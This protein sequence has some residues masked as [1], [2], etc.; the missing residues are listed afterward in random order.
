MLLH[1]LP[2]Q[3]TE[4]SQGQWDSKETQLPRPRELTDSQLHSSFVGVLHGQD[5]DE[6]GRLARKTRFRLC[7]VELLEVVE[8]LL[9]AGAGGEGDEEARLGGR[10]DGCGGLLRLRP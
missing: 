7:L 8:G 5:E 6:D 10:T 1:L 9:F 3:N 2:Q 4:Q